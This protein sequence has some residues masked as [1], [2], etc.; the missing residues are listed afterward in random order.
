MTLSVPRCARYAQ[1][2]D[3]RPTGD[4]SHPI[5]HAKEELSDVELR[6]SETI[7][8]PKGDVN[9]A[10]LLIHDL[11]VIQVV[12]PF[13]EIDG[14]H[15][16]I[17]VLVHLPEHRDKLVHTFFKMWMVALRHELSAV[18]VPTDSRGKT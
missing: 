2:E 8:Q 10:L 9:R 11:V 5:F 17:V 16:I 18:A 1:N 3:T 13:I 12:P 14:T 6:H 4:A 7:T 15:A